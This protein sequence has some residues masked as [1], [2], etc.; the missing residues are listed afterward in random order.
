MGVARRFVDDNYAGALGA[1]I[2]AHR[3]LFYEW[4]GTHWVEVAAD[5]VRAELYEW[6]EHAVYEKDGK[7]EPF[8]PNRH[9]VANV[10]EALT[11]AEHVRSDLEPPAWTHGQPPWGDDDV[12]T[13]QN[14]LLARSTRTLYP[15]S[16]SL[17]NRH[18]LSFAYDPDAAEPKRWL[19]F[20]RELW[21]DDTESVATLQEII[22]YILGGGTEQQKLFAFIGPK[23]SGKGTI[24]RVATALLGAENVV[25]PT[26]SALA[27]QFGLA[28]LI[29]KPLAL[30]SDARL[31]SRRDS[32][33]AVE[34]L[35]AISGEDTLTVP[36]KYKDDWTGRLPTR[37]VL[38]SNE[39]PAFEDASATI[40]SRFE[41][42]MFRRS[43]YGHENPRLTEELLEEAPAIFNWALEGLDRLAA[44]GRFVQPAASAS[45]IR[46]LEDL[47][48]PK[49][50][51]LRD[52][53]VVDPNAIAPKD[54]V[55]A[56][57][58]EWAE[59][60]GVHK[61]SKAVLVRDLRAVDPSITPTR[62]TIGGKRVHM[63]AGLR[64]QQ[65]GE[66]IAATPDTPDREEE[67]SGT[68]PAITASD[69]AQPSGRSGVSGVQPIVGSTSAPTSNGSSDDPAQV[70]R[71]AARFRELGD[72]ASA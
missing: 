36:R 59:D 19:H 71:L 18:V 16:P 66:T 51:F 26:L 23:R 54:D 22:G 41:V 52:R 8:G 7:S 34:R 55:W 14:G 61:Q 65:V 45:A 6:L 13:M 43:F 58:K 49:S 37:F 31:G 4:I 46:H 2:A 70:E 28:S 17:F 20:L 33:V 15:H 39:L 47:A 21:G 72:E 69:L 60:A 1:R 67:R 29:G 38:L 9:K 24:W 48:S 30:I 57:W 42:V 64:L 63:L 68:G 44:R 62:P 27:T 25:G 50:A 56:A 5:D 40:A 11:A 32:Y 12:I 3:G 10:V 53:C 35:L